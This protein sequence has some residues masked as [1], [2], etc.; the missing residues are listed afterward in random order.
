MTGSATPPVIAVMAPG[1]M[2]A[3]VAAAHVRA[4]GTALTVLAGRGAESRARAQEAGLTDCADLDALVGGCDLFL[5]IVP[6]AAAVDLAGAVAEAMRRTGAAPG[7]VECNA[8]SPAKVEAIA[9]LFAGTGAGFVDGGIIGMPPHGG[10]L[11]NL[12]V[13]GA[14]CPALMKLDGIGFAIRR[15]GA[16]PGAAS[17]MKMCYA[18]VTKGVN[19]V[20]MSALLTAEG[21]GLTEAFMTEL[22]ETQQGLFRRLEAS[23]PRLHADAGRWAPEMREIS[24]SFASRGQPGELHEGA[25]RLYEILD[26]S[27]IGRETRRTLDRNRTA[28]ETARIID[29]HNRG[30]AG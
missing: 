20:L 27:P 5:S 21:F 14:D 17:A 22:S 15:L 11:P 6:P 25:A 29:V 4:G 10:A 12:Y 23:A 2:G 9:A 7:F 13:S 24:A 16:A 8:I 28:V 30:D 1:E 18:G 19:A 26:R 3:A